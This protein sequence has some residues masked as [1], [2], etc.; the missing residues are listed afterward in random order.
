MGHEDCKIFN[1]IFSKI[2]KQYHVKSF[3]LH[4]IYLHY[5]QP[6]IMKTQQFYSNTFLYILLEPNNICQTHQ[7]TKPIFIIFIYPKFILVLVGY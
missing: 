3:I 6:L 1:K 4:R 2:N 7:V 5:F